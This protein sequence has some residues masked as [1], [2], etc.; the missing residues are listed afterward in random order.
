MEGDRRVLGRACS[1]ASHP[2]GPRSPRRCAPNGSSLLSCPPLGACSHVGERNAGSLA[3]RAHAARNESGSCRVVRSRRMSAGPTRA[4]RETRELLAFYNTLCCRNLLPWRRPSPRPAP[5]PGLC[6]SPSCRPP[7]IIA[8]R[9][10]S[11]SAAPRQSRRPSRAQHWGQAGSISPRLARCGARWN[12]EWPALT[13]VIR[14]HSD[15]AARRRAPTRS[16]S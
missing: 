1:Q 6:R 4:R 12:C 5:A 9:R 16:S 3:S 7:S 15:V 13:K 14:P 8:R 2:R 10:T 11:P